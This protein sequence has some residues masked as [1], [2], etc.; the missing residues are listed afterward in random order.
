MESLRMKPYVWQTMSPDGVYWALSIYPMKEEL[1][2]TSI[3][4]GWHPC[5]GNAKLSHLDVMVDDILRHYP[6]MSD[7]TRHYI[8]VWLAECCR[9]FE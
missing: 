1:C 5:H 7:T 6:D 2:Y 4:Q 3:V 9:S 8:K